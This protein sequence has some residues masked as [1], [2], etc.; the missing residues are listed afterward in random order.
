MQKTTFKIAKMDCPS[1]EQIIRMKLGGLTNIQTLEFDLPNRSLCIYHTGDNLE[2]SQRL[3]ELNLGARKTE[4]IAVDDY[5]PSNTQQTERKI[6]WIVLAINFSFFAIEAIAGLLSNSMGLVADSLDMLADS[7]V[8]GLALSVVGATINKK[9]NVAKF[10][11]YFQIILAIIGLVEV[12]RRFTGIEQMPDFQTM[13]AISILAL[14]ANI[15]CLYLLTRYK[16]KEA[17]IR[18]TVIFSSNDVII[19]TGVIAAGILVHFLNS[20]YPDLII[21]AIVFVFVSI[22]AYKI[23]QLAHK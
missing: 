7:I 21:G 3:N 13:I 5:Q 2:I 16:S 20:S 22:G 14:T 8:Y 19:N 11:A 15:V 1:E 9:K 18:A 6:L 17:H 10:A 12:V 23:L 4:T